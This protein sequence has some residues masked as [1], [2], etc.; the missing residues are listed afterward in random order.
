L[1]TFGQ[2]V[3]ELQMFIVRSQIWLLS[4]WSRPDSV[5]S[6]FRPIKLGKGLVGIKGIVDNFISFL[7]YP[8]ACHLELWSSWNDVISGLF[9]LFANLNFSVKHSSSYISMLMLLLG[10][11]VSILWSYET[12]VLIDVLVLFYVMS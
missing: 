7:D 11:W 6:S 4:V 1:V 12:C 2:V 9:M 3:F 5:V 8:L 10:T